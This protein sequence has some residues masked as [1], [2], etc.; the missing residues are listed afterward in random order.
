MI[1][2]S[3]CQNCGGHV[4]FDDDGFEPGTKVV[5]PHC[6]VETAL[7]LDQ[8]LISESPQ[9]KSVKGV[10]LDFAVQTNAGIISGDD[11][12]RYSFQGQEWKETSKFPVKGM[13]VD[14]TPQNK[15]ATAI[16]LIQDVSSK[17]NVST[18]PPKQFPRPPLK[19]GVL[20]FQNPENGFVEEVSNAPLWVF[21]FGC[22]YFAIKGVWTHAVGA[23]LAACLTCGLSWLVYPFYA[24]QIMRTHFSRKGWVQYS[25]FDGA[26]PREAVEQ[27]IT[28]PPKSRLIILGIIL[29]VILV[30]L[31]MCAKPSG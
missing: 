11:G 7:Y 19:K 14:F 20:Q 29:F 30:I 10:I 24:D 12:Q 1:A 22:F 23:F 15:A 13:R 26:T 2:K 21:L 9:E 17:E 28:I 31:L 27:V 4:E 3:T 16:Y 18:K 25:D 5:C 8:G 6:S